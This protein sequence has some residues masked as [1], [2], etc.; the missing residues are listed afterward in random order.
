MRA[1]EKTH[2]GPPQALR[3]QYLNALA[4]P[5]E[6]HVENHVS[7]GI[8]WVAGED[9]YAVI[10]GSTLVEL[11][12]VD[13][14]RHQ[15]IDLFDEVMEVS[16]SSS[17]LCKSFDTQLLQPALSRAA[18]VS[19]SGYLFRQIGEASF[20][21]LSGID[22]KLGTERDAEAILDFDDGFFSGAEEITDYVDVDGLFICESA[23]AIIGCGIARPVISGRHDVGMLVSPKY[24]RKDIGTH[25]VS[26]LMDHYLRRGSR[27]ICGCGI[28]NEASRRT[29]ENAGFVSDHRVLSITY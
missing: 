6:L 13:S 22:F 4:E 1:F 17:V 28:E 29:L 12:V 25:I 5:Q 23:E 21:P 24:R 10:H 26:F 18:Q 27:P 7:V 3:D 2:S 9:A 14:L 16:C 19:P 15:S 20:Q 11:F 8:T